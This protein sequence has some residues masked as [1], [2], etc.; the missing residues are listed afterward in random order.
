MPSSALTAVM[1]ACMP[2]E[3]ETTAAAEAVCASAIV[4]RTC[5]VPAPPGVSGTMVDAPARDHH[6]GRRS[7]TDAGSPKAA[8]RHNT[9]AMR[10]AHA[11]AWKMAARCAG[12]AAGCAKHRA[13]LTRCDPRARRSAAGRCRTPTHEQPGRA[14][15]ARGKRDSEAAG[16]P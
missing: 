9:T 15:T 1:P 12:S 3:K 14:T 11:A 8:R 10:H 16:G 7:G 5:C 2:T 13:A 6:E 4:T